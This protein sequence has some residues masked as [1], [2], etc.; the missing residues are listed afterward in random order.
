MT[1]TGVEGIQKKVPTS[2]PPASPS[3]QLLQS[4][5]QPISSL[6]SS[7]RQTRNNHFFRHQLCSRHDPYVFALHSHRENSRAHS[8]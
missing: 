7:R 3:H 6:R 1:S 4:S 2:K 5:G 8:V